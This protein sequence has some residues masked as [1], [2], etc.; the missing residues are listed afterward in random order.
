[1][2][3]LAK[4]F[5]AVGD[6]RAVRVKRVAGAVGEGSMCVKYMHEWLAG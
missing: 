5:V 1:M 6:V 4:G 3:S 2:T